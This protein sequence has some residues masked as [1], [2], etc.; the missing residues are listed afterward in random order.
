M[1]PEEYKSPNVFT[2]ADITEAAKVG[3]CKAHSTAHPACPQCI[4]AKKELAA[5]E[6]PK[7]DAGVASVSQPAAALDHEDE[8]GK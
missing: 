6:P 7:K 3:H 4:I 5:A 8:D 2:E 1:T